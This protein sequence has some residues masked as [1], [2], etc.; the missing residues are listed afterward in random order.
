MNGPNRIT[1]TVAAL[2]A[3]VFALL[4]APLLHVRAANGPSV[5]IDVKNAVPRQVEDPTEK[6][7]ER[8]YSAAWASMAEALDK[9]RADLLG[10]NFVGTAAERLVQTVSQQQKSGLHQRIVDKGH[11][12][13]AV[14]YSPEGSAIEL[15]D[16]ARLQ[17]ELLDGDKVVYSQET[18]VHYVALMTAAENSWKVRILQAV[19]SS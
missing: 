8:D 17:I 14:F 3:L 10:A 2:T 7:V 15:R 18:T 5:T 19:P 16:A 13:Q 11:I 4:V 9:N 1:S 12:V 6:A